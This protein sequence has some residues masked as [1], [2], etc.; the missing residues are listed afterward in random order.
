MKKVSIVATMFVTVAA[1]LFWVIN[2]YL[3]LQQHD[4]TQGNIAKIAVENTILALDASR[5]IV[6]N[7]DNIEQVNYGSSAKPLALGTDSLLT[8]GR[9]GRNVMTIWRTEWK[10]QKVSLLAI[11]ELHFN[12]KSRFTLLS[13]AEGLWLLGETSVLIRPNGQR[14][15]LE[16]NF[17]EPVAVSLNDHSILVLGHSLLGIGDTPFHMQQL[18]LAS[19]NQQ[20]QVIDRGLLS[21]NGS[22]NQTGLSYRAPRY[23]HSAVTLLDGRVLLMGGDVTS[24]LASLVEPSSEDGSWIAKPV[25]NMPNE[26]IFA[27]ATLLPDGR[28]VVTGAPHL[29]CH[30][31]ANKTRGVDVYDARI[32]RWSSL[33]PTPFVPC[34][35]AYGANTPSITTTPNGSLVISGYLEPQVMVLQQDKSSSTGYAN[36]WNV[37]GQMPLRRISGVAQ[38][39]SDQEVIVAGGV[40]NPD[41]GFGNCCH[42]VS[43]YDRI[44]ISALDSKESLALSFIGSGVAKRGQKVFAASGRRFGFTSTGQMRY[45]TYAELIDLS[46]GSVRQLPNVPF[47][48][49]AAQAIWLNDDQVLLKGIKQA[50]GRGFEL[51]ND[52]SSHIPPSSGDMAIFDFKENRWGSLLAISELE[53]AHIIA[54]ESNNTLL[55]YDDMKVSRLNLVSRN[56]ENVR[57]AERGRHGGLARLLPQSQLVLAGGEVQNDAVSVLDSDC[58]AIAD[59]DCTEQFVGFGPYAFNALIEVF[60]LQNSG[61]S[62]TSKFS[63]IGTDNAIST[64]ITSDGQVIVLSEDRNNKIINITRSGVNKEE[65]SNLPIPQ[66]LERDRDGSCGSCALKVTTDPRDLNEDLIFLRQGSIDIDYID[67]SIANQSMNVW[68]WDEASKSWRHVLRSSGMATRSSPLVLEEPLTSKQGKRMISMGWHLTEPVLWVEP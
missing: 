3:D 38:A 31:E 64:V 11:P 4:N 24:M 41:Q 68:L 22:P 5:M 44:N 46:S 52:L 45:S 12:P 62:S 30:G 9:D 25:I 8:L 60:T 63:K 54:A 51:N 34:A 14:L 57:Q 50:N 47:A 58:N 37:Y 35:D 67:A 26:R 17:N 48:S 33:P 7:P 39:L 36:S 2:H 65:W 53:N 32:N 27:A 56:L 55:F 1:I 49:G 19:Y 61:T 23:G 29:R 40:N 20:L 18:R 13:N 10:T 6:A 15:S 16:T 42:A 21:Y 43:D 66:D 59:A 28:V